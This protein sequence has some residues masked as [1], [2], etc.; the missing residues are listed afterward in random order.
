[1]G[2][3]V[4]NINIKHGKDMHAVVH[5][6]FTYLVI[7]VSLIKGYNIGTFTNRRCNQYQKIF[8]VNIFSNEFR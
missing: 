3:S 8:F 7:R 2:R 6:T 5:I 1:M 4:V